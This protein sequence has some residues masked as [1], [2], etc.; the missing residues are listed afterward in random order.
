MTAAVKVKSQTYQYLAT[1]TIKIKIKGTRK[2]EKRMILDR[3]RGE[4]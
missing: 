4:Q 2:M 3:E 1:V